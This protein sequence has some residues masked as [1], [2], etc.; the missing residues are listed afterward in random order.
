[1]RSTATALSTLL[2]VIASCGCGSKPTPKP[3]P[4]ELEI[5]SPASFAGRW[6]ADDDMAFGYALEIGA[7][8]A[9]LLTM[10]R[11]KLGKCEQKGTL[12]AGADTHH[13]KIAFEKNTCDRDYAGGTVDIV[14]ESFT[15]GSL[16][17]AT[18][19]AGTTTRRTYA[20]R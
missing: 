7:D 3:P 20:Q 9:F 5:T 13:Y 16:V 1:M 11:G 14:I 10:D 15:R 17:V 8:G 6:V 19:F 18:T 2:G 12:A 4:A